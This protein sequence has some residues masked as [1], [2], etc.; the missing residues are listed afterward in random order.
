[1]Q[2]FLKD[3]GSHRNP[4]HL[5]SAQ[6]D[7]TPKKKKESSKNVLQTSPHLANLIKDNSFASIEGNLNQRIAYMV[8]SNVPSNP[9]RDNYCEEVV[10]TKFKPKRFV[11]NIAKLEANKLPSVFSEEF[12]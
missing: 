12:L 9:S 4:S 2:K 3:S 1:M 7:K 8:T 10:N 6:F 11:N 5:I